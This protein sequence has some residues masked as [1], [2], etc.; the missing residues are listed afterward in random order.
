MSTAPSL[1]DSKQRDMVLPE[2]LSRIKRPSPDQGSGIPKKADNLF[3]DV[4][5]AVIHQEDGILVSKFVSIH[6]KLLLCY[7][8]L[9]VLFK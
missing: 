8:A 4:T 9:H 5:A 7:R 3:M 2:D 1:H 6:S